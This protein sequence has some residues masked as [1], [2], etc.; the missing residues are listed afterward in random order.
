MYVGKS[1]PTERIFL[2]IM[3]MLV[4]II[5]ECYIFNNNLEKEG[6]EKG[7]AK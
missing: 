5:F 6:E 4:F 2:S 1:A 3:G 7:E